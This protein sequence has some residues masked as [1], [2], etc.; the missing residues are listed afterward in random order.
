MLQL[1]IHKTDNTDGEEDS[2]E[3]IVPLEKDGK[4][5]LLIGRSEGADLRIAGDRKVSRRHAQI[6][7]TG[8]E[9]FV[10]DLSSRSGTRVNG[11]SISVRTALKPG[12]R[13][14]IGE[15]VLILEKAQ[16]SSSSLSLPRDSSSSD[17]C[18]PDRQTGG[19][20]ARGADFTSS[21]AS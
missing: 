21:N 8:E 16:D 10:E 15:T 13:I 6:S 19:S 12:D 14:Q 7:R 9:V 5:P 4:F 2:Q 3:M 1:R 18:S 20:A 17:S 11:Q